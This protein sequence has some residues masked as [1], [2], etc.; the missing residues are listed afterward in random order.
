M[1]K[2]FKFDKDKNLKPVMTGLQ[3]HVPAPILSAYKK[4]LVNLTKRMTK[5]V[6]RETKRLFNTKHSDDYFDA[7]KDDAKEAAETSSDVV[8]AYDES[9]TSKTKR[10]MALLNKKYTKIF[11]DKSKL[12]ADDMVDDL[13]ASSLS[14]TKRSLKDLSG[15]LVI[16]APAM[17]AALADMSAAIIQENIEL[18]TSIPEEY[19]KNVQGSMMRSISNGDLQGLNNTIKAS[20][21]VSERRAKNIA[22]DQV[23][24]GYNAITAKRLVN[25]GVSKFKWIHSGGGQKPRQDHVNMDGNIYSF[26][27]LPIIDERTGERGVPGQ[28]INC[29]CTMNPVIELNDSG[30]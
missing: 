26:D 19:L 4:R 12:Y 10:L 16:K 7:Q 27:D 20:G 11:K 1:V 5:E 15:G 21:A 28:A 14:Y 29:R 9:I 22:D 25:N 23:R 17:T 8:I 3:A 18:I 6:E 30:D 24:K 13:N 2:Q